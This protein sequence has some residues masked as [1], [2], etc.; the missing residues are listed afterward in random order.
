MGTSLHASLREARVR[1]R[2]EKIIKIRV[3][4][5]LSVRP[6]IEEEGDF[7]LLNPKQGIPRFPKQKKGG[8]GRNG[9]TEWD[10]IL[11]DS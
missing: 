9:K 8:G 3:G 11:C 1:R 10:P 5:T 6:R 2:R 7:F 4:Y